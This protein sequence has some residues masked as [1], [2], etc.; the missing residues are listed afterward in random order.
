M[1]FTS[2]KVV[3]TESNLFGIILMIT[4]DL[5]NCYYCKIAEINWH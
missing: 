1:Q 4:I 2:I 3:K 5:R